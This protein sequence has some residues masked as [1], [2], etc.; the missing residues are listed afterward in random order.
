MSLDTR[1]WLVAAILSAG[2]LAGTLAWY[3]SHGAAE[4]GSAGASSNLAGLG[5]LSP[6]GAYHLTILQFHRD[7]GSLANKPLDSMETAGWIVRT[8]GYQADANCS[9]TTTVLVS[10]QDDGE[11]LYVIR[12]TNDS[13]VVE[14]F[15]PPG[16]DMGAARVQ[17]LDVPAQAHELS[18]GQM[19]IRPNA[20]PVSWFDRIVGMGATLTGDRTYLGS[21]AKVYRLRDE[22][23]AD[24]RETWA[25]VAGLR[26]I[27]DS[28]TAIVQELLLDPNSGM[29]VANYSYAETRSGDLVLFDAFEIT[30]AYCDP[31]CSY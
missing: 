14:F 4:A 5:A 31:K 10:N 16:V 23:D 8:I 9:V 11:P 7:D 29:V 26:D 18:S 27:H 24:K 1:K 13:E 28:V 3:G 2:T 12:G 25:R 15:P 20:S 19:C 22:I 17:E 30:Q 21:E 6:G